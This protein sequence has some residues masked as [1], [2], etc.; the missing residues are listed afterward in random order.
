MIALKISAHSDIHV[1][2]NETI[3]YTFSFFIKGLKDESIIFVHDMFKNLETG[4]YYLKHL[5]RID[6]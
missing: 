4:A 2:I 6:H 3:K 1:S 5:N